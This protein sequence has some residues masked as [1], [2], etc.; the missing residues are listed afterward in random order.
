MDP[1]LMAAIRETLKGEVLA[2][3]AAK[4]WHPGLSEELAKE[5]VN[6]E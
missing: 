4:G 2:R 6:H 3:V 5:R 1:E